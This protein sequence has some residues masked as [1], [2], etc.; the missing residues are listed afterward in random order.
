MRKMTKYLGSSEPK[1][2]IEI[3]FITI[4]F[5]TSAL[6]IFGVFSN[7]LIVEA[8]DI[9]E[10]HLDQAMSTSRSTRGS[11]RTINYD[12]N[13]SRAGRHQDITIAGRKAIDGD[14]EMPPKL[15]SL[16][17]GDVNGDGFDDLIIGAPWDNISNDN[18]CGIVYVIFGNPTLP[19]T[20]DLSTQAGLVIQGEDNDDFLGTSV[21]V[22][23]V[24]GDG[25]GDII[26]GAPGGD[27]LSEYQ[28]EA[29]EVYIFYGGGYLTTLDYWN[30]TDLFTPANVTID[31]SDVGDSLGSALAIGNLS[32]DNKDD[33]IIGA[34]GGQG[35]GN[36]GPDFGEV[37]IIM[38]SGTLKDHIDLSITAT[39]TIYGEDAGD[40]FGKAITSGGDFNGDSIEDIVITA[41][42]GD[43]PTNLIPDS[44]E[45]YIF[46]WYPLFPI[47]FDLAIQKANFTLYGRNQDDILGKYSIAF[48]DVNDDKF[49]DLIVGSPGFDGSG[50]ES[51]VTDIIYGTSI[52]TGP[53]IWNLSDVNGN[54]S[55]Y[56]PD[57]NDQS[58][59]WVGSF[60]WNNDD[61]DDILISAPYGDGP[62]NIYFD[63]GEVIAINGSL[64]LPETINIPA[65]SPSFYFY[66][67]DDEDYL[68]TAATYGDIN[69][70]LIMDLVILA[71]FADGINNAKNGTGD[72]Y[73]IFGEASKLPRISNL[74][75]RNAD[76]PLDA[77]CYSRLQS[78]EFDVNITAPFGFNNVRN[79]TIILDPLGL[80]MV[81]SWDW[82]G[83]MGSFSEVFDP[84]N[85]AD[86]T[87]VA[88]NA[89][90]DG[91]Y[92][93]SISFNLNFNWTCPRGGPRNVWVDLWS[94]TDYYT[95]R[96]FVDVFSIENQ[97]NFTGQLQVKNAKNQIL[98]MNDWVKRSE[99]LHWTNLK[100]IYEGTTAVYPPADEYEVRLWNGSASWLDTQPA[101]E[102]I[103]ITT[104]SGTSSLS[105]DNY[106]LNITKIPNS[107]DVSNITFTLRL[108]ADNIHFTN[109]LPSPDVWQ[110][111]SN[112]MCGITAVDTGGSLVVGSSI[113][114]RTSPDNGTFWSNWTNAGYTTNSQ[115]IQITKEILFDD[116]AD[117]LIQWR[118]N[119][120]IGN[121]YAN[122]SPY[123]IKVDTVDVMFSNPT[124]S[125]SEIL[126]TTIVEFGIDI[127]DI[128]SGI[129][130]STIEY[131]YSTNNGDQWSNWIN[132][133]LNGTNTTVNAIANATLAPGTG[134]LVKWRALDVAG[135]GPNESKPQRINISIPSED[136]QVHLISPEN[137]TEVGSGKR[138]LVWNCS[139][140]SDNIVF[141]VYYSLSYAKVSSFSLAVRKETK[142]TT[143][144]TEE[145]ENNS[146]YYWTVIPWDIT[147]KVGICAD[148]IWKFTINPSII[149]MDYPQITVNSPLNG[150]EIQTNKPTFDWS[151]K[152]KN[153]VGLIYELQ[154][155]T[156]PDNLEQ[157]QSDLTTKYFIPTEPLENNMTYY[158]RVGVSGGDLSKTYWSSIWNFK[159]NIPSVIKQKYDFTLLTEKTQI[160]IIQGDTKEITITVVNVKDPGTVELSVE[161]NMQQASL[162]LSQPEVALEK[163]ESKPV[164]LTIKVPKDFTTGLYNLR[165]KGEMHYAGETLTKELVFDVIVKAESVADD[166]DEAD[167][168]F[169]IAGVAIVI[170]IIIVLV[171]LFLL[172]KHKKKAAEEPTPAVGEAPPVEEPLPEAA[173]EGALPMAQPYAPPPIEP[174]PAEGLPEQVPLTEPPVPAP[175][176]EIPAAAPAAPA[177]EYAAAVPMAAM[178]G[179][180]IAPE[181]PIEETP[182]VEEMPLEAAE[183][184]TEAPPAEVPPEIAEPEPVEPTELPSDVTEAEPR[185]EEP[186]PEEEPGSAKQKGKNNKSDLEE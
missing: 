79:V 147:G 137:N 172:L 75:I 116:G 3:V 58:G 85:Y 80:H 154:L 71:N 134:N 145:L 30:I 18:D 48:G 117:N 89:T 152:Y 28:Y 178:P 185:A 14:L 125:S 109:P 59:S 50:T 132:L 168:T 46:Y 57:S 123:V 91:N 103:N 93:W 53:Y 120:S 10:S 136:L 55:I 32:P 77:T 142:N 17:M 153:P 6:S 105:A 73:V 42:N 44:G 127:S 16:A 131:S 99:T 84:N 92:N 155:G 139:D 179:E 128:T 124:P 11:A 111:D 102:F 146:A 164:K 167:L 82:D 141:Y 121:G 162:S 176:P 98:Q 34:P 94:V 181:A 39:Y 88:I 40:R 56:F 115:S 138:I 144:E 114:Y 81:Y 25:I 106:I 43:G 7:V 107:S 63:I 36:S 69:G 4:M 60:D 163:D 49:D 62:N 175:V 112:V 160:E 169:V 104:V 101:G 95:R 86:L 184:T 45:A 113:E 110:T 159:I 108:D 133:G 78:Y 140:S 100:V 54:V 171:L 33:L 130:K 174:I 38:G 177:V 76:L 47:Y 1:K 29:G 186:A 180:P 119:D 151:I 8:N 165:V 135:N 118:G 35:F 67:G 96:N 170:I 148:G 22:G 31:G 13:L 97:L 74:K 12:M 173:V 65:T 51:G 20:Y 2:K 52:F 126:S 41:P 61:I 37:V 182:A 5:L 149:E 9:T 87:S 15:K 68:G 156:S 24:N 129:N 70:D 66:G 27:G 122:S 23:D 90:N 166:D 19:K 150:S 64:W 161:S 72:V 157:Y 183:P 158:W 21:A 26:S 83:S 143:L